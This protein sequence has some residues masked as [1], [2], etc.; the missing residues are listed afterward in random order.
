M[1]DIQE[2]V[3]GVWAFVAGHRMEAEVMDKYA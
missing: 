2:A 3:V 1:E